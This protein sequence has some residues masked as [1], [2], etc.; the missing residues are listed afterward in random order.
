[1]VSL[2]GILYTF[3]SSFCSI[4]VIL[5]DKSSLPSKSLGSITIPTSSTLLHL[6]NVLHVPSLTYKLVS[7]H[8][9]YNN[10]NC[11]A[12]FAS[13]RFLVEGNH[14]WKT[15]IQCCYDDYLYPIHLGHPKSLVMSSSIAELS[16]C[17]LGHPYVQTLALLE[18]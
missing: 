3:S 15:L 18:S 13:S 14:T 5:G 10:N 7:I 8:K 2:Q 1:M 12:I 6:N 16:H 9:L 17:R 4:K 11:Y